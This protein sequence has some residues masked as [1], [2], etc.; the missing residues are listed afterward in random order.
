VKNIS[1]LKFAAPLFALFVMM[2]NAHAQTK[3][4]D[5]VLFDQPLKVA[6]FTSKRVGTELVSTVRPSVLKGGVYRTTIPVPTLGP[7]VEVQVDAWYGLFDVAYSQ[8]FNGKIR[9]RSSTRTDAINL[10]ST[11]EMWLPLRVG[12][13]AQAEV[14]SGAARTITSCVISARVSAKTISPQFDG[15]AW[16]IDCTSIDAGQV[17][18]TITHFV[19][20][21]GLVWIT[22]VTAP[23][24]APAKFELVSLKRVQ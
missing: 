11:K 14:I 15:E 13:M 19:D 20:S 21:L 18:K 7:N 4:P 9:E 23:G 24:E 22:E 8:V 10:K 3:L 12:S 2:A 16:K 17:T 1:H 5:L 6:E